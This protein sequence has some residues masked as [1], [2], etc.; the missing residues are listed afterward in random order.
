LELFDSKVCGGT[1]VRGAFEVGSGNS[2]G[3]WWRLGFFA[4]RLTR[5]VAG[6][7]GAGAVGRVFQNLSIV[8]EV[9]EE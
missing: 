2:K 7:V 6:A 8:L 3:E 1:G 9:L 5:G 4:G